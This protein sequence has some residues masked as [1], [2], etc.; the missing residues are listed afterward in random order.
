MESPIKVFSNWVLSGKDE[1]MEKNHSESVKNMIE[2][3]TKGI[4][5]FSF[6][7]AGCGNGWVIRD[8]SS[9]PRCRQAIGVDGSLHMIEKA[10]RLDKK[11]N[12]FCSDL[13]DWTPKEKVD[14]VHSMEVFY[15]FKKPEILVNHIYNNWLNVGG[16]LIMGI[17]HYKE[18]KPSNNW[19]EETSISIMQ[20]FSEN[21]W[22][23]FFKTAGFVNIE[24]WCYGKKDE[25]NGTLIV[26]GVK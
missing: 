11:N 10:K 5:N 25:W 26:T 23:D 3:S 7:D 12:Y 19:K 21:T 15:Y 16:R 2:Y 14:I 13:L 24:S 6:I 1:G 17:D 22:L 9:D 4:D 18:N 20:L 8:I